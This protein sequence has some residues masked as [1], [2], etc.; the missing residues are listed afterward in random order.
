MIPSWSLL[1]FCFQAGKTNRLD[2]S[3]KS[4]NALPPAC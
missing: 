3:S 1:F 2:R 4:G